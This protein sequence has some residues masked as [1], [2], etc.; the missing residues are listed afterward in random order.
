MLFSTFVIIL[1]SVLIFLLICDRISSWF[2]GPL[3][4][5]THSMKGKVIVITGASRGIGLETV[6]DLLRQGAT[7]IMG[8]RDGDKSKKVIETL[9]HKNRCFYENLDLTDYKSIK[10]FVE[11]VL[12]K[13]NKID[14]LI[15]NAGSCFQYFTIQD[16]I[17][18]T[19]LTNHLGHTI[20]SC[21]F[22]EHFNPKG[23][24][25]N[26]VTTKYKRIWQ[27]TLNAFTSEDNIDFSYNKKNYDWMKTYI[28]SKLAGVHLA[29]YLGDYCENKKIGVKVV[30]CHP[31]F[32]NNYFFRDIEA[33]SL[34]WFVRD[35]IMIPLRWL[36]F[37]DNI[38]GAQTTL[39]CTYLEYENLINKGYYRDCINEKIIPIGLLENAKKTM[40]FDKMIMIQ[41]DIIKNEDNQLDEEVMKVFSEFNYKKKEFVE[42]CKTD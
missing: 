8:S 12:E 26:L 40:K 31:G 24:I 19:Y 27:K 23:R 37:K 35:F 9:P 32:I 16:G 41:N 21:L 13:F 30:S 11:A 15:N 18:L 42:K 36:I 4:T 29:Q 34:Y 2:N 14:V 7:V 1:V 25:I 17:E 10:E 5:K 33:H 22:L 38:N 20:L 6:R 39:H 28:L 3:T